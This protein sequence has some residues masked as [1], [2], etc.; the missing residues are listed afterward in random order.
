M[1]SEKYSYRIAVFYIFLWICISPINFSID[2]EEFF[3]E[4]SVYLFFFCP[5][6]NLSNYLDYPIFVLMTFGRSILRFVYN[7]R[8]EGD[9]SMLFL[10]DYPRWQLK[11]KL[12]TSS[13]LD[14]HCII[15]SVKIIRQLL[16]SL[17]LKK[18]HEF[19]CIAMLSASY[20]TM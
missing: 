6:K 5:R 8:I 2:Y 12:P 19:R 1:S 15:Q 14:V 4:N 7:E 11:K 18:T 13:P 9:S 17:E 20:L 3:F 16:F 10:R